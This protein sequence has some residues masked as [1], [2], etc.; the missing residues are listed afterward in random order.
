M[1]RPVGSEGLTAPLVQS[2][3]TLCSQHPDPHQHAPSSQGLLPRARIRSQA[4]PVRLPTASFHGVHCR[5]GWPPAGGAVSRGLRVPSPGLS[6]TSCTVGTESQGLA[7]TLTQPHAASCLGA[8]SA[9]GGPGWASGW[10]GEVTGWHLGH[11]TA[12]WAL[13]S[14]IQPGELKPL[15]GG[16]TTRAKPRGAGPGSQ[17]TWPGDHRGDCG[18]VCCDGGL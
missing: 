12:A 8:V 3:C 7:R 17:G 13:V 10:R 2:S 18:S 1:R 5:S 15:R 6:I 4:C 9:S 11:S 16:G 14:R